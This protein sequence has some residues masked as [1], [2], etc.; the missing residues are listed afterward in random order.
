M[1][2]IWQEQI[3]A[4]GAS[5]AIPEAI[6]SIAANSFAS[7]GFPTP[8]DEDWKYTNIS[9]IAQASFSLPSDELDGALG[10]LENVAVAPDSVSTLVV[11][12]G[13]LRWELS[14][15][16]SLPKGVRLYSLAEK[17]YLQHSADAESVK[18]NLG[19]HAPHG[20]SSLV[21]LNTATTRDGVVLCVDAGVRCEAPISIIYIVTA[22]SATPAVPA[23]LL[24]VADSESSVTLVESFVGQSGAE[25]FT[26]SVAE[27][28][29]AEHAEV[30]HY[31]MQCEAPSAFHVSAIDARLETAS[32]FSTHTFS[33]GG[34]LVRN[35]IRAVLVGEQAHAD[36]LGLSVLKQEQHVDNTTLLDHVAPNCT[37]NEV[38]KGIYGDSS[39]GVFS[40]TI[41][42][43]PDAQK[44]NAI[45]SNQA[46]L[47]SRDAEID[48]RPQLKIWADDVRCTHGAT[49]GQLDEDQLFYLRARGIQP[50][51]ARDMLI[52]AFAGEVVEQIA[53]ESVREIVRQQL[54]AQLSDISTNF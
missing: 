10:V 6:R 50:T 36:L 16:S 27:F 42:V 1:N 47:L 34:A 15:V 2:G 54:D 14:N 38:Y 49:V 46:L 33:F 52:H 37:S 19:A 44:T 26:N 30:L 51:V 13:C 21:A 11:V 41:I 40:G 3:A 7:Q 4:A 39:R 24:V 8:R 29:L 45:Q 20:D 43:R 9:R 48:S 53:V 25:Y 23:R 31:R 35:E 17:K 18:N 5:D 32:R 28:Y 22:Q 12:N